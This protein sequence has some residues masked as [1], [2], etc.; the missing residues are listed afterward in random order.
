[1]NKYAFIHLSNNRRKIGIIEN[2]KL[3]Y[4][5]DYSS[6][7]SN[8]YRGQ[9]ERYIKSMDSFIV[10]IGLDK[11]A[12]LRTKNTKKTTKPS[13]QIIVE[14]IA[15]K[16]GDKLY[17]VTEKYTITDGYL[18]LKN[19]IYK[20]DKYDLFL[21]S[22]GK[23]LNSRELFILEN[24]LKTEFINLKKEINFSPTPKLIRSNTKMLDFIESFEGP[25]FNN[26]E[27]T[28]IDGTL[29][30]LDYSEKYNLS[31]NQGLKEV[32]SRIIELEQ[33]LELV[34]DKTEAC[35]VIDINTGS[36]KNY[37]DKS[38]MSLMANMEVLDDLAR[39]IAIK[40]IKKMVVIDFLR[41]NDKD[42]QKEVFYSFRDQLIK[43]NV[44]SQILG[45]TKMGLFEMIVQ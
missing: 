5:K 20:E 10:D 34:F 25:V 36:Y 29:R 16:K 14:V 7:I 3:V 37:L 33:G 18:V 9:V 23:S 32:S 22:K 4:Y 19:N 30:D 24:A 40:N 2:K 17:E 8:I 21:R 13:Y 1:M 11:K 28:E 41:M 15:E 43:Y 26:I 12:L 42:E 44:K 31:I 38:K 45:F 39:I 35:Y 27:G 6:P